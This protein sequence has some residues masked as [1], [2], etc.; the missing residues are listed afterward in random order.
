MAGKLP[1]VR[2]AQQ[3]DEDDILAMCRRLH[4]ENGLFSLSEQKVR[5]CIRKHYDRQGV[6][7][8]VIGLPGKLEAS[9]CLELSGFY[10]T[11]DTHLAELWNFVDAAYRHSHN[12]EA[13]IQFGKSCA[14]QM[15][16]PF[17]TGII[18]NRQMAGKVR[19][20]RRSLGYPT[21][22]F[23]IHNA[24]WKPEP[25]EDHTDLRNKLRAAAHDCGRFNI[26]ERRQNNTMLLQR[27]D[28]MR[29]AE[30]L[31]EAADAIDRCDNLWGTK[32]KPS[33]V[34]SNGES[35]A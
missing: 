35:A 6:I 4:Q 14:E 25:M 1:L 15:R 32:A 26:G 9:T 16:M 22:A 10:Y 23:F 7:V 17:F 31:R 24:N 3:E 34:A 20:Y 28:V 8:G 5:A 12:A 2:L 27:S 30:L 21:G 29:L 33:N 19:L 13:L 11:D 18:T